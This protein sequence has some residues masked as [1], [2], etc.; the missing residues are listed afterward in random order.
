MMAAPLTSGYDSHTDSAGR[1]S[2]FVDWHY[3]SK[4][5]LDNH[6]LLCRDG[7]LQSRLEFADPVSPNVDWR[8]RRVH[9]PDERLDVVTRRNQRSEGC[10]SDGSALACFLLKFGIG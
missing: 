5:L 1:R 10:I 7:I 8:H 6:N 4:A 2:E 9:D 3:V